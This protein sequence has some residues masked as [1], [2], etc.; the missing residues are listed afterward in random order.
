MKEAADLTVSQIEKYLNTTK[1]FDWNELKNG[2]REVL[3]RYLFEQTRRRPMV[4]P[5]VMEVNQNRRPTAHKTNTNTNP[6]APQKRQGKPNKTADSKTPK[7]TKPAKKR[8][9]K[10]PAKPAEGQTQTE[11]GQ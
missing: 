3:S 11:S 4:M 9:K 7:T 10:T 8:P 6:N 2:V 5:V 1:S